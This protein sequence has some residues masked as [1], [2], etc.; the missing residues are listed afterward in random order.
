MSVTPPFSISRTACSHVYY[1][2]AKSHMLRANGSFV[3][4]FRQ[5][6]KEKLRIAAILFH[7]YYLTTW[8]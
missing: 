5:K 4:A 2:D 6:G 8:I 7:T 3:I 1:L